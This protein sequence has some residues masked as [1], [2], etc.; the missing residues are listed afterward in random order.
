MPRKTI[1]DPRW[2]PYDTLV[3]LYVTAQQRHDLDQLVT[4]LRVSRSALLRAALAAGLPLVVADLRGA[5]RKGARPGVR[6]RSAS[7]SVRRGV[8]SA[9]PVAE[10]WHVPAPGDP[11]EPRRDYPESDDE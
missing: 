4:E 9:G 6:S 3:K 1:H 8:L 2:A 7:A 11:P 10:V 5:R